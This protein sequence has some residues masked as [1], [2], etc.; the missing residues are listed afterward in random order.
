MGEERNLKWNWCMGREFFLQEYNS[1]NSI[2]SKPKQNLIECWSP[3][4]GSL[5]KVN[6]DGVFSA[7][8]ESG[9]GVIIRDEAGLVVAVMSKK[10]KASLGPLEIEAKTFE[11]GLQ[12]AKDM[13]YRNL[14]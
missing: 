7:Q 8:K 2:P 4:P 12:F 6:V 14:F 9:I 3:P 5:Y 10:V 1:T 11:V 13:G